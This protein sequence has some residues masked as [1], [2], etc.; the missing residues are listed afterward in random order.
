M[1]IVGMKDTGKYPVLDGKPYKDLFR[2]IRGAVDLCHR[3]GSLKI[4]V[5]S[6]PGKYIHKVWHKISNPLPTF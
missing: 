6:N 3:D 2:D 5:A 4:K 1:Q